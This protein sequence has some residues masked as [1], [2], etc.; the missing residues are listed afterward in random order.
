MADSIILEQKPFQNRIGSGSVRQRLYIFPTQHGFVFATMVAVMLMG[1]VNYTNSMAYMLTFLLGSLFMV[2]MLH[3]YRNLRGLVITGNNA[4]PVFAGE[5]AEFP[6][7]FDNRDGPGRISIHMHPR[8]GRQKRKTLPLGIE[9]TKINPG[10]ICRNS[11]PVQTRQ[12]GYLS[13]GRLKIHS[14]YPLGLFRAWSYMNCRSTCLVY[15]KP[16]G[17][18]RLPSL[19]EYSSQDQRGEQAG[20]DDF[21]GFRHYRPGDSIRNIDWKILAREQGVLVKKFSGSGARKLILHWDQTS[22]L[23][24]IEK[25][26]SQ[27]ALWVIRAEQYGLHYG[28][29]LPGGR[30]DPGL[31]EHHQHLCLTMLA[32]YGQD[33]NN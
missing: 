12:R 6:V 9:Y 24:S 1:A 13:P 18:P 19:S 4:S 14:T 15:P 25:R 27:L 5:V 33:N 16:E 22:H 11:L 30:L 20:T 2:S 29:E 23:G 26:L 17:D 3:T 31:G 7:V 10:Q 21:T 28:L 8:T 32:T